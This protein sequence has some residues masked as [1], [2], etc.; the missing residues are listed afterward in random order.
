M[1]Y[2]LIIVGSGAA[3]LSA[4]LYAGRYTMKTL[5]IGEEFGGLTTRAGVIWNYPGNKGIDGYDLMVV[6]RDQAKEV[7]AE[8]KDGVVTAV[9]GQAGAF[10]VETSKGVFKGK[11]ILFACGT[12]HRKLGLPNEE[13]LL[14]KGLHVCAICDGP[15]YAQKEVIVV[16]GGDAS[17]KSINI[18]AEYV[19]KIYFLVRD[20]INAEPINFQQMKKLGDKVEVLMNTEVKEIVGTEKFEKVILS[21][22]FR[23]SSE[24]AAAGIFIEVGAKPNVDIATAIGVVLD[25]KGYITTTPLAETNI[26]GAF[27]AGDTTN[28]FG[29]FKQ[30]ITAAAM[31][32]VAATSAYGFV[33]ANS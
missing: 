2:D 29:F 9:R 13:A 5:V 21:K 4:A 17:V 28:L 20:E 10:E 27:A 26:P 19:S 6:M 14:G 33:K 18:I 24:L 30:D 8:I 22:P 23:G 16:G 3:G 1:L 25:E 31:G 15:I 32:A 12:K 11:T 7:G